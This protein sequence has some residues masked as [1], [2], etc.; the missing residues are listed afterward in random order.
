M[1]GFVPQSIGV[2]S[3]ILACLN[4]LLSEPGFTRFQD[5][6]D[7]SIDNHVPCQVSTVLYLLLMIMFQLLEGAFDKKHPVNPV[8]LGNAK[9]Q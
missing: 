7:E 2:N 3:V 6:Q 5:F 4:C 1:L 9:R 8:I